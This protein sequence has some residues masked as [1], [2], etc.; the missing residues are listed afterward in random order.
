[1]V[2][3]STICFLCTLHGF[4]DLLPHITSFTNWKVL[5]YLLFLV[6][7]TPHTWDNPCYTCPYLF[8]FCRRFELGWPRIACNHQDL[9]TAW[10]YLY[11]D[12]NLY[13]PFVNRKQTDLHTHTHIGEG[14]TPPQVSAPQPAIPYLATS[15]LTASAHGHCPDRVAAS[16]PG[17]RS[18]TK[19]KHWDVP[20]TRSTHISP[21]RNGWFFTAWLLSPS[22]PHMV[23]IKA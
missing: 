14:T 18:C 8:Q 19:F 16:L 15:R 7:K 4:T 21:R 1:M 11:N 2:E 3:G 10:T 23:L 9:S 20:A 5:V 12:V 13:L 22:P 6:L 17:L